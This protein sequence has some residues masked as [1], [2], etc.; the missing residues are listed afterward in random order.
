LQFRLTAGK[1]SKEK[2]R[3]KDENKQTKDR[4]NNKGKGRVTKEAPKKENSLR[5][6]IIWWLFPAFPSYVLWRSAE[7][8]H[9]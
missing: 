2:G 9:R 6:C 1:Y 3:N 4:R 7:I 8:R 5:L